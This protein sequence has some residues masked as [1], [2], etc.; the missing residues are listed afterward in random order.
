MPPWKIDKKACSGP[1]FDAA[2]QT[3][4]GRRHGYSRSNCFKINILHFDI[5]H[6]AARRTK[7]PHSIGTLLRRKLGVDFDPALT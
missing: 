1:A 3:A 7:K 5:R 4:A 6:G 2:R